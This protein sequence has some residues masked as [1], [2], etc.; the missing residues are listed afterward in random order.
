M[1][2]GNRQLQL[3]PRRRRHVRDHDAEP[4][5]TYTQPG[6]YIPNA[7]G[8]RPVRRPSTRAVVVNVCRRRSTRRRSSRSSSSRRPPLPGLEDRRGHHR[9]EEAR[10]RNG[11][12]VDAIEEPSLFTDDFLNRY[13]A[14]VWLSTTG[15]VLNDAAAGGVRALHPLRPRLRGHPRRRGHRVHGGRGTASWWARTSATTRTARRPRPSSPR[16]PRTCPRPT[17]PPAG[18]G[19]RVVQL[20]ASTTPSSTAA[21]STSARAPTRCTCC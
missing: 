7:A 9:A 18:R 5:V 6:T 15:D 1:P 8:D 13:D 14:V 10:R 4:D 11:F 20:P 21:A 16:T 2:T 12:A 19:G 17:C 3:G